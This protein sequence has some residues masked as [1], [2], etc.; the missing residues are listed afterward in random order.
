MLMFTLSPVYQ[1]SPTFSCFHS[2]PG[3]TPAASSSPTMPVGL[4]K[5]K[6]EANEGRISGSMPSRVTATSKNTGLQEAMSPSARVREPRS[7]V[8]QFLL[9]KSGPRP[10]QTGGQGKV[11]SVV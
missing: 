9:T 11:E 3:A 1:G 6:A 5:P 7:T 8:C 4:P 10:Y 2:G